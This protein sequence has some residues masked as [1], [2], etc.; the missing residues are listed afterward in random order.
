MDSTFSKSDIVVLH[1]K[2]RFGEAAP[3]RSANQ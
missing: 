1:A 3:Q 2:V